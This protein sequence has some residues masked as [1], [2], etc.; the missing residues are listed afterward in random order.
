MKSERRTRTVY[1]EM[2]TTVPVKR[3]VIVGYRQETYEVGGGEQ[4]LTTYDGK[5]GRMVKD[6]SR[7][8]H[9]PS[10]RLTRE[11]PIY[12][13]VT[14]MEQ[15]VV[16]VPREIP[17]DVVWK[18]KTATVKVEV[19]AEG[20]STSYDAEEGFEDFATSGDAGNAARRFRTEPSD[21]ELVRA[22]GLKALEKASSV[23]VPI[24]QKKR[25]RIL[26]Q[27]RAESSEVDVEEAFLAAQA[28]T[29]NS[30]AELALR[31]RWGGKRPEGEEAAAVEAL[32]VS[33]TASEPLA[34]DARYDFEPPKPVEYLN[35]AHGAGWLV[36]PG[37]SLDVGA[38][39]AL[40]DPGR[41]HAWLGGSLAPFGGR[42]WGIRASASGASPAIAGDA[43]GYAVGLAYARSLRG[44]VDHHHRFELVTSIGVVGGLTKLDE[45]LGPVLAKERFV[46]VPLV[47]S[48]SVPFYYVAFQGQLAVEPN[49]LALVAPGDGWYTPHV[50]SAWLGVLPVPWI[51]V[52]AGVESAASGPSSAPRPGL[53]LGVRM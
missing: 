43:G 25:E 19:E 39:A 1:D 6:T 23:I 12:K 51:S 16:R 22:A 28:F 32:T 34:R 33:V 13:T 37:V 26:E 45:G 8:W 27:L 38:Q 30:A 42:A 46:R 20:A 14:E 31:E 18:T 40:L 11:K 48:V 36:S 49:V 21:A 24:V 15:Q 10:T 7:C 5:Y 3:E 4:C 35:V 44:D 47:L 52:L 17:Y 50:G 2:V 9:N 29:G 53:R 41:T